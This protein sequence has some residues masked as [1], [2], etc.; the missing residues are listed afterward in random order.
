MIT[1]CMIVKNESNIIEE[2]LQAIKKY[3]YELVIV[4]TGSEDNTKDIAFKYTDKVY[5]YKWNDNF[6][7]ARN[8]ALEKATNEFILMIDADEVICEFNVKKI[9]EIFSLNSK[10]VGRIS[11]INEFKC[12]KISSRNEEKVSRLFSK[13]YYKYEGSIHEQ[14]ISLEDNNINKVDLPLKVFHKGYTKEEINRKNKLERNLLMLKEELKSNLQDPYL[15]YQLGK[16]YYLMEDYKEAYK[17]FDK[18]LDIDLDLNFE[19]VEELIECYGYCLLNMERYEEALK[20]SN[21][22]EFFSSSSDFVFLVGLI[23]MNNGM[24]DKSYNEFIKAT[25]M[26]NGKVDGV[27]GNLAFYNIGVIYECLGQLDEAEKFY[28]KCEKFKLA[29][30]GIGRIKKIDVD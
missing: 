1:I 14:L 30:D 18:A 27:N 10:L 8:F 28:L 6:S 16:T 20:I 13:K 2:T 5:D 25:K 11:I 26:N 7:D 22:Y 19:Y 12:G 21:L 3:G 15:L 17:Y 24:F 9:E 29:D 4:D 23:Y